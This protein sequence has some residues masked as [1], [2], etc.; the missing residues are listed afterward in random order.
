MLF[1]RFP[2]L[3][4]VFVCIGLTLGSCSKDDDPEPAIGSAQQLATGS[5]RLDTIR[6]NGQTTSSG[7][8]IKDRFTFTFRPNGT[9]TQTLLEDGD[10]FEG[11][12]MLMSN[13]TV[14]HMTD[15]KGSDHEYLVTK[16][17]ATELRYSWTNKENEL[18]EFAFSSQP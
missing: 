15:H 5:W 4:F 9:Y 6:E 3:L 1:L 12:W 18:E 2:F 10:T 7:A 17:T 11:T 16:L 13:N 14:L 8:A